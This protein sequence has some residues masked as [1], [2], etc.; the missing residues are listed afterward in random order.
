MGKGSSE[1]VIVQLLI[2][3]VSVMVFLVGNAKLICLSEAKVMFHSLVSS[4]LQFCV[5]GKDPHH[6]STHPHQLPR[7]KVSALA[8]MRHCAE[9]EGSQQT[10]QPSADPFCSE[11]LHGCSVSLMIPRA[12]LTLF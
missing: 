11:L 1:V 9:D 12:L 7:W 6:D 3:Q 2:V 8:E 10:A 5:S 4:F